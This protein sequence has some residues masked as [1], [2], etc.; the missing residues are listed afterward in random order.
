MKKK[1]FSKKSGKIFLAICSVIL[2]F[3]FWLSIKYNQLGD[4]P[5][6]WFTFG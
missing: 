4:L 5:I 3:I 1:F 6:V 2:A